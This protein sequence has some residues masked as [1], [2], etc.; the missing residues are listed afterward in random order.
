TGP[1]FNTG[2][3]ANG[4]RATLIAAGGARTIANNYGGFAGF[5]VAGANPLTMTGTIDLNAGNDT[6][7]ITN[8]AVTTFAGNLQRGGL[9]KGVRAD[10]TGAPT[11]LGNG[12]LV[13][14]GNN[15]LMDGLVQ[16][17][18]TSGSAAFSAGVL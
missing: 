6:F 1:I 17:G 8:T 14:S 4:G 13:L 3:G 12:T 16:I 11:D 5:D 15:S 2:A 7:V 10:S 9:I 18:Q